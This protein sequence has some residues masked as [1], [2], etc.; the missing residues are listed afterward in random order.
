MFPIE[1]WGEIFRC[2]DFKSQTLFVSSCQYFREKLMDK[3]NFITLVG[4]CGTQVLF[5]EIHSK[6]IVKQIETNDKIRDIIVIPE[7]KLLVTLSPQ[8]Q[9]NSFSFADEFTNHNESIKLWNMDNLECIVDRKYSENFV[10]L[11]EYVPNINCIVT[12][13]M[14]DSIKLWKLPDLKFIGYQIPEN[15]LIVTTLKYYP[16]KNIIF[17]GGL[18]SMDNYIFFDL[19]H[20]N[21]ITA[22][23][24]GAAPLDTRC[25]TDDSIYISEKNQ[26]LYNF[27]YKGLAI[28]DIPSNKFIRKMHYSNNNN[29]EIS[30]VMNFT[31]LP[32]EELIIYPDE[33]NNKI[34]VRDMEFK[35]IHNH[36]LTGKQIV[37]GALQYVPE[38]NI[39]I[40][41]E[42][43]NKNPSLYIYDDDC[44]LIN[45]IENFRYETYIL[46]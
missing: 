5:I 19:L 34:I 3:M 10:H 13:H 18:T 45:F 1:I 17:I 26:I 8:E 30:S 21:L 4:A 38:L 25:Y 46:Q 2:L 15:E 36:R 42:N 29:E 44:D 22:S 32:T 31:Y 39:F 20:P 41:E 23:K 37:S 33:K 16:K 40:V 7:K 14:D 9:V 43:K 6:K 28:F 11:I 27:G 35:I 12:I 24:Y